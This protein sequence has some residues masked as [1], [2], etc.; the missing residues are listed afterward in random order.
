M[1]EL[2]VS[3]ITPA[4]NVSDFISQTIKS[5]QAQ[6]IPNWEM[7]IID[8][9]STDNTAEVIKPFLVD[10][11]IKYIYQENGKQGKARNNG[12]AH[13]KGK[14][15]AFLDADDLWV[16][17]KLELQLN[18]MNSNSVDLVYSQ[19]WMFKNDVR[20]NL[21]EYNA[22]MGLQNKHDFLLTLLK[23]NVIPVLSVLVKKD[24]V[25]SVQCFDE[26]VLVQ[27]AEDYQ[28]WLKLADHK[29]LFYGMEERLFYYRLHPNQSTSDA[30]FMLVHKI[31]AIKNVTFKSISHHAV[32][33]IVKQK[34][35]RALSYLYLDYPVKKVNILI[36][37]YRNPLKCYVQFIICKIAFLFSRKILGK[38]IHTLYNT[39][40][41]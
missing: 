12:I 18:C 15:L 2:L 8:D 28:L 38:T 3:I 35:N 1:N 16:Q 5:V 17:N 13:S 41:S 29:Y 10:N 27:N 34:L 21:V 9:G 24:A 20:A 31:W 36:D 23:G 33:V 40:K 22:P 19:G 30:E 14:Y 37:L 26:H 32:D 11:R 4:Y 39:S 25:L 6:T 7:I